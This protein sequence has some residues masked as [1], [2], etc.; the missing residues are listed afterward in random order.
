[1]RNHDKPI[2]RAITQNLAMPNSG[3]DEEQQK[4]SIITGEIAE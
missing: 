3:G 2:K 4:L 1:M